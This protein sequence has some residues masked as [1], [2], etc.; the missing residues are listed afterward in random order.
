MSSVIYGVNISGHICTNVDSLMKHHYLPVMYS[1][2][3]AVGLLGKVTSIA[4]Y[5]ANILFLTC[6]A[7]FRYVVVA[8][9]LRA[10]Q[11]QQKRWGIVAYAAVWA[12]AT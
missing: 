5:L 1:V 11:V 2:I 7:V 4:I 10:A 8:H 9:P 12:I 3:F 6:L